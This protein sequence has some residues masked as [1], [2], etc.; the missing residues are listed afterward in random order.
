MTNYEKIIAAAEY[1]RARVSIRPTIGLVLGSGLGDF[2]DTLEDAV[3]IPYSEIPNFPVPT[4]PGHSGSLVFGRKCGRTVVVL[5]GRIHYYEGL[6]QQEITRQANEK[7]N[8]IIHNAQVK[9]NDLCVSTN[10]Y[11]DSMLTRVEELLA[12]DITDVKKA[13]AALKGNT[14]NIK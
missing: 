8:E 7:A 5:Q 3:R 10:E 6:S 12:K 11:V 13:R 9:Y 4:V 2:A 14:R 1:I